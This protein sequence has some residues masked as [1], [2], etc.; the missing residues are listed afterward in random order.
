LLKMKKAFIIFSSILYLTSCETTKEINISALNGYWEIEKAIA[1][2]GEEKNYQFNSF[3][4][5]FKIKSDSTGYKTK[6]KPNL[7]GTYEGNNIKQVFKILKKENNY[8][9]QYKINNTRWIETLLEANAN[10]YF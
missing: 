9:I 1:P 5:F 10:N 2:N 4:D 3:I 8:F 6:L 7:K